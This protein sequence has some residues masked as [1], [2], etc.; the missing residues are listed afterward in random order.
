MRLALDV[1]FGPLVAGLVRLED[2][3]DDELREAM[4]EVGEVVAS[5]AKADHPYQDRTGRLTRTTR[6]YAPRGRFGAGTLAVEV[7][8]TQEYASHVARRRGDWLEAA[9]RRSAP[10]VEHEVERALARAVDASG[11]R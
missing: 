6:A 7:V 2:Q 8:A 11:L 5:A 4:R 10:R 3:L 1:D 9:Y